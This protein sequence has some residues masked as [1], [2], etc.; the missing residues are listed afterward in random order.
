MT[1][2]SRSLDELSAHLLAV[3][4]HGD[5][6]VRQEVEQ[7]AAMLADASKCARRLEV[8]LA[9]HVAGLAVAEALDVPVAPVPDANPRA[10]STFVR[11]VYGTVSGALRRGQTLDQ[12]DLEPLELILRSAVHLA[13]AI[14]TPVP[15]QLPAGAPK[16]DGPNTLDFGPNVALFPVAR[17]RPASPMND[18]GP[19]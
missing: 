4:G 6:L 18:G 11:T 8:D 9:G 1:L 17:R 5:G 2:L 3:A 13:E 14:A 10:L 7:F 12:R 16:R 15:P 19:S